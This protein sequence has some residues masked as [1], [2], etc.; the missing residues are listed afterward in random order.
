MHD[1][2]ACCVYCVIGV[3]HRGQAVLVSVCLLVF[4][5]ELAAA[6]AGPAAVGPA[7]VG[8]AAVGPAAVEAAAG[9]GA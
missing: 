2:N 9:A 5:E 4:V 1:I 6:A 7:A 8:P 3:R